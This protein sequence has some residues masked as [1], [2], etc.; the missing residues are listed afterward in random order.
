MASAVAAL[1]SRGR[2]RAVEGDSAG[3][4]FNNKQWVEWTEGADALIIPWLNETVM[5]RQKVKDI[6]RDFSN[7][8]NFGEL[9]MH[10]GFPIEVESLSNLRIP[11]AA[12]HNFRIVYPRLKDLPIRVNQHIITRITRSQ[13]GAATYLLYQLMQLQ[14]NLKSNLVGSNDSEQ[15]RSMSDA[16]N[17]DTAPA[18]VGAD[19]SSD[20]STFSI[21]DS[22]RVGTE[23]AL[24]VNSA[25]ISNEAAPTFSE[26]SKNIGN[27]HVHEHKRAPAGTENEPDDLSLSSPLWKP[28]CDRM[29]R[30]PTPD[31]QHLIRDLLRKILRKFPPLKYPSQPGDSPMV[32]QLFQR[33][34][35]LD[36]V[37]PIAP[38]LIESVSQFQWKQL[39]KFRTEIYGSAEAATAAE[40][41][42]IMGSASGITETPESGDVAEP[43]EAEPAKLSS[44]M[45]GGNAL[46]FVAQYLMR[47]NPRFDKEISRRAVAT[48][49]R[50]EGDVDQKLKRKK[51]V[52]VFSRPLLG[53]NR[54]SPFLCQHLAEE[55]LRQEWEQAIA[56]EVSQ[57]FARVK[58]ELWRSIDANGDGSL[59][60]EEVN[61]A[62]PM[63]LRWLWPELRHNES[64]FEAKQ[65]TEEAVVGH[66]PSFSIGSTS[67]EVHTDE[68]SKLLS[69]ERVTGTNVDSN[70][71]SGA[72]VE[73]AIVTHRKLEGGALEAHEN[74]T[75][76]LHQSDSEDET[77]T[78]DAAHHDELE[79]MIED[80]DDVF[81]G[82]NKMKSDFMN[83]FV[84]LMKTCDVDGD[85]ELDYD[86]FTLGIT[87]QL[88]FDMSLKTSNFQSC[89]SGVDAGSRPKESLGVFLRRLLHRKILA[90]LGEDAGGDAESSE[91][92]DDQSENTDASQAPSGFGSLDRRIA[93][94]FAKA[95]VDSSGVLSKDQFLLAVELFGMTRVVGNAGQGAESTVLQEAERYY[96]RV[97]TDVD[98]VEFRRFLQGLLQRESSSRILKAVNR[99]RRNRGVEFRKCIENIK[100]AI[101]LGC[102]AVSQAENLSQRF[103]ATWKHLLG[104]PDFV[105]TSRLTEV[106]QEV[107]HATAKHFERCAADLVVA[108]TAEKKAGHWPQ[109]DVVYMVLLLKN[110]AAESAVSA[111]QRFKQRAID[112]LSWIQAMDQHIVFV[113]RRLAQKSMDGLRDAVRRIRRQLAVF[114]YAFT[115]GSS[116]KRRVRR[117]MSSRHRKET[118]AAQAREALVQGGFDTIDDAQSD[119]ETEGGQSIFSEAF[120]LDDADSHDMYHYGR[121]LY[122]DFAGVQPGQESGSAQAEALVWKN[123]QQ[124]QKPK[125]RRRRSVSDMNADET[126]EEKW[127]RRIYNSR[128]QQLWGAAA[129]T[130]EAQI[131]KSGWELDWKRVR[132]SLGYEALS[133]KC[134]DADGRTA[135]RAVLH[136]KYPML[137]ALY[138]HYRV[139]CSSTAK[140]SAGKHARFR[141]DDQ[142]LDTLLK[143]LK[144]PTGSI[145]TRLRREYSALVVD[146]VAFESTMPDS[147]TDVPKVVGL[148]RYQ[149][150]TFVVLLAME[151]YPEMP[152]AD[153]LE[154]LLANQ[155]VVPPDDDAGAAHL[156][157]YGRIAQSQNRS[158]LV[159]RTQFQKTAMQLP[160]VQAQVQEM[161]PILQAIFLK[162]CGKSDSGA[163]IVQDDDQI[164]ECVDTGHQMYQMS[165]SQW[166][167][168]LRH[169]GLLG[170]R[171]LSPAA[172]LT[173][174]RLS[175]VLHVSTWGLLEHALLHFNSLES[176]K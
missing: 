149:F 139:V 77:A 37:V 168:L 125:R 116:A 130:A 46:T 150:L 81:G 7:G 171:G 107:V 57:R 126:Q 94:I 45:Q 47:H 36:T 22:Q 9:L 138:D 10:M 99:M 68:L 65:P 28:C 29:F 98:I 175:T 132:S 113:N 16:T 32:V 34:Q 131:I 27:D 108:Q 70:M 160:S 143:D 41:N 30:D 64:H 164:T 86:E 49:G 76:S 119:E 17:V 124:H 18:R 83:N 109:G 8:F 172:A 165:F 134:R 157:Q 53:E 40:M 58:D 75:D 90:S 21:T 67:T 106:I 73:A 3:S 11:A 133:H 43:L 42:A 35:F 59:D 69:N 167:M 156:P 120:S 148:P 33:R 147:A 145:Q 72:Q 127:L 144:V 2:G 88:I 93:K 62:G 114:K 52:S 14:T 12:A 110:E 55:I 38:L 161:R 26:T 87:Q 111:A 140:G 166:R 97:G 91:N 169:A 151:C 155:L 159:D 74:H 31:P 174:F 39:Q 79:A 24:N 142:S 122:K 61:A 162:Y 54:I 153:A 170:Y 136:H 135:I 4:V 105:V 60:M 71:G 44:A 23:T 137:S 102:A 96:L 92:E 48:E 123:N 152:A 104:D 19:D 146:R 66:A 1:L 118:H 112:T 163:A 158:A 50:K 80:L 20:R 141:F 13:P 117:H 25:G 128:P 121:E 85:G 84:V 78:V 103:K 6:A 129:Q 101:A 95:D 173:V 100:R 154:R 56:V 82:E 51:Y 63:I 5:L 89:P 176:R 15:A 115:L